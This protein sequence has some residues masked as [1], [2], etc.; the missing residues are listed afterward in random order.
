MAAANTLTDPKATSS[1]D[2]ESIF[3]LLYVRLAT[4]TLLNLTALA[5]AEAA[6]LLTLLFDSPTTQILSPPVPEEK[7]QQHRRRSSYVATVSVPWELRVLAIRLLALSSDN[8]RRALM[9]YYELAREARA[10]ISAHVV[11]VAKTEKETTASL[12]QNRLYDLGIRVANAL[13]EIG[14]LQTAALHLA[15][16]GSAS[17]TKDV[18]EASI[19]DGNSM[20]FREA[21]AWLS[22]GNVQAAESCL[23]R[24]SFARPNS[25]NSF[26]AQDVLSALLQIANGNFTAAAES[27]KASSKAK[28]D[29]EREELGPEHSVSPL[30][31]QNRAICSFY[32]GNMNDVSIIHPQPQ[33][34]LPLQHV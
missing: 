5:I 28:Q 33:Y 14:D 34:L 11:A 1:T 6:P 3:S 10:N 9:S 27:W 20:R 25:S 23:K 31:D 16:L 18:D 21:L 26:T 32:A 19:I 4:L 29:S 22:L 30:V 24:M 7:Q 13:I 15:S 12:W 17:E 8:W 2:H